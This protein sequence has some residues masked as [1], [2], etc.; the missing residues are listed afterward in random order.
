MLGRASGVNV[1]ATDLVR[2]TDIAYIR[3]HEGWLY[4]AAVI[5]RYSRKIVEWSMNS[6]MQTS[7]ALNAPLIAVWR[8]KPTDKVVVHSDQGS[9]F[10]SHEWREFLTDHN[11]EASMSRRGNCYDNAVAESFFHLLKTERVRRETYKTRAEALQDVFDYI[12]IFYNLK[13]R[14]ANN[15]ILSPVEFEMATK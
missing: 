1:R 12:E 3:T 2:V 5:D 7:L 8:L 15:G 11:L 9:Q 14:H 13:R 10:T 4:L 6:R